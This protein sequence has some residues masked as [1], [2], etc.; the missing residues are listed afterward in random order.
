MSD[1]SGKLGAVT[2]LVWGCLDTP[3]GRISVACTA[4][5]VARVKYADP[6]ESANLAEAP[7]DPAGTLL[8]TA[9]GE[10]AEYFAGQRKSFTVPVDL[11]GTSGARRTVLSM[12]HDSVGFGETITYGGLAGRSGLTDDGHTREPKGR[13]DDWSDEGNRSLQSAPEASGT[14]L[15]PARVVGQVM[16]SNPI[17]IIV[18]CHRVVAGN[19]LGGYSGG[20]GTDIK[21]WL[22]IFEGALPATLDW[23]PSGVRWG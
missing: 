18:P 11:S 2:E 19:G 12:L 13:S 20:S 9:L 7:D 15:P 8:G 6:P 22:L 14:I 1:P 4:S 10:L 23:D 3:V 21:Q 16:A 5:G 17:A